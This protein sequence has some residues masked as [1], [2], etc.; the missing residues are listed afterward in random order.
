VSVGRSL[1]PHAIAGAV[2][3]LL[4]C[5]L[6]EAR[7]CERFDILSRALPD[8]TLRAFYEELRTSEARHYR[9]FVDLAI[10]VAAGASES[11]LAR[12]EVLAHAEGILVERRARED[13]APAIHG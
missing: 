9:T 2:D 7:S 3:R 1:L 8:G 13:V 11:V 4:T 12:L 5:A 6:I 10:R